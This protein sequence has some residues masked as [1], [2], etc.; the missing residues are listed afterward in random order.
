MSNTA[1][2]MEAK[3]TLLRTAF[4]EENS[5]LLEVI[6][7]SSSTHRNLTLG[8]LSNIFA[9]QNFSFVGDGPLLIQTSKL[10]ETFS[11][12]FD[13][14][15]LIQTSKVDTRSSAKQFLLLGNDHVVDDGPLQ[16]QTSILDTFLSVDLFPS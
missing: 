15:L 14:P 13:S 10:E 5:S 6:S 1:F 4:Q 2:N 8:H 9:K 3:S 16:I 12:G 11:L 7:Q